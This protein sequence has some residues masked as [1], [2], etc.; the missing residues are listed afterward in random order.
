MKEILSAARIFREL[1]QILCLI[2]LS[3][4][5]IQHCAAQC[6]TNNIRAIKAPTSNTTIEHY[7]S[8]NNPLL[9]VR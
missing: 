8:K 1:I 5:A 4:R 3:L 7:D 2:Y 9:L 6:C